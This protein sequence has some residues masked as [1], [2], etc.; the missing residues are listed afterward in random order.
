MF[1]KIP[2]NHGN[3]IF[4]PQNLNESLKKWLFHICQGSKIFWNLKTQWI[5]RESPWIV[6]KIRG[7]FKCTNN[8]WSVYQNPNEPWKQ[9]F[10]PS[11]LECNIA[12]MEHKIDDW[13]LNMLY[14]I[15]GWIHNKMTTSHHNQCLIF[16]ILC[17]I[18]NCCWKFWI[19]LY[20]NIQIIPWEHVNKFLI[21]LI[22]E[23]HT[24]KL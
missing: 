18:L 11:K 12:K 15:Q 10:L 16:H 2:M 22:N 3:N 20:N 7:A 21:N 6:R 14:M 8:K 19:N 24:K 1:T 5:S 23:R 4:F 13:N 9:H 17:N